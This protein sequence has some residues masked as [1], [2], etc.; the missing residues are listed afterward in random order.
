MQELQSDTVC[1]TC[2][3]YGVG[4]YSVGFTVLSVI[5]ICE[6]FYPPEIV[7]SY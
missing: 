1:I 4:V 6:V 5:V 2:Y 7:T 3:I